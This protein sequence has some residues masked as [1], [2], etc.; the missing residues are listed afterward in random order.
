[1][2][3]VCFTLSISCLLLC[4]SPMSVALSPFAVLLVIPC[5]MS[6]SLCPSAV[7]CFIVVPYPWHSFHLLSYSTGN[8]MPHVCFTL[9]ISCLLLYCCPISVVLSPFA[10][11]LVM[12]CPMSVSLCPSAAYCYIV[13]PC[14]WHSVH[15]LS[16][17]WYHA[18]CLFH[19]VPQLST[20][21]LLSHVCGT[22]SIC[23]LTCN[24][25]PHVCFTLSISCLLFYCCPISMALVPFAVLQYW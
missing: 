22:Q 9:A 14:L 10:V 8:A 16:Y 7:Y 2:P 17:L 25:M 6:V 11:F 23:C 20:V 12:P 4:C 24:T 18:P 5:P 13:V 15:L 3:H 19:S 1:M 21:I